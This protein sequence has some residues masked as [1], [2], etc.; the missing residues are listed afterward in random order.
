[1]GSKVPFPKLVDPSV[2]SFGYTAN[3]FTRTRDADI[4]IFPR[5]ENVP[6]PLKGCLVVNFVRI[7]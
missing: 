7:G 6:C 1:M 3:N 5:A 4:T 2:N